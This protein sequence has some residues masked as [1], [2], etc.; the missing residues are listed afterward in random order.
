[1]SRVLDFRDLR[2]RILAGEEEDDLEP[3]EETSFQK[4]AQEG[5]TL[6]PL[7]LSAGVFSAIAVDAYQTAQ[8]KVSMFG[9]STKRIALI[10]GGVLPL[11]FALGR[12]NRGLNAQDENKR[13]ERLLD[14]ADT[15]IEELEEEAQEAE[16]EAEEEKQAESTS[17]GYQ[18]DYLSE[19]DSSHHVPSLGFGLSAFGQEGVIFRPPEQASLW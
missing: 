6:I 5:T 19:S 2:E 16:D 9:E 3:V 13:Y 15:K 7:C 8:G 14:E 10:V 4:E 12:L 11:G 1:M 17:N 18:I